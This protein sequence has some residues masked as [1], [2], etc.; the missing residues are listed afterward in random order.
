MY[1]TPMSHPSMT[2]PAAPHKGHNDS[3]SYRSMQEWIDSRRDSRPLDLSASM[4]WT[5]SSGQRDLP[6]MAMFDAREPAGARHAKG[7]PASMFK[8][9]SNPMRPRGAP[10][11]A[12][13]QVAASAP[14]T[15]RRP[16]LSAGSAPAPPPAANPMPSSGLP[17]TRPPIPIQKQTLREGHG[18]A[19]CHGDV[20]D[21]AYVGWLTAVGDAAI[22]DQADEFCFR[23][24]VRPRTALPELSASRDI[25]TSSP[26]R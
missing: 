13:P 3:R 17:T 4:N 20:I 18:K 1:S 11:T 25:L 2:T 14:S 21:V 9:Q 16:A 5:T 12:P 15:G 8:A 24:G 23:L 7:F 10:I 22:F 19:A 26:P 6:A